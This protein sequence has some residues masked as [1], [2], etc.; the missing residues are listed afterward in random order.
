MPSV[1]WACGTWPKT[2]RVPWRRSSSQFL[3]HSRSCGEYANGRLRF[4]IRQMNQGGRLA[5]LGEVLA[6]QREVVSAVQTADEPD[7]GHAVPVAELAPQ[8]VAGVRRVGDHAARPHDLAGLDDHARL[9]A[10]R[11]DVEVPGHATS[12]GSSPR[13]QPPG[14]ARSSTATPA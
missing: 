5:E 8:R 10:G 2:R 4:W 6:Y 13:P 12:L 9:R 7:P 1:L 11:I 14:T 3:S